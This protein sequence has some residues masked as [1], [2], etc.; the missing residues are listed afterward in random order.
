MSKISQYAIFILEDASKSLLTGRVLRRE[1]FRVLECAS[2][3]SAIRKALRS[4][5]SLFIMEAALAQG[6][7]LLLCDRIRRTPALC[8]IP[9]IF[10]SH[11]RKEADKVAGLEAGADDYIG[12]PFGSAS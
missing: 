12:K 9:V 2:G 6:N 8:L 1:G 10:V 3:E 11:R 7:G 4:A 5:P